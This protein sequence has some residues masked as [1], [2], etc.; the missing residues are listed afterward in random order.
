MVLVGKCRKLCSADEMD[1]VE[2]SRLTLAGPAAASTPGARL[3]RTEPHV[4]Y[5][6]SCH[7]SLAG[8]GHPYQEKV[9]KG[10]HDYHANQKELQNGVPLKILLTGQKD[11]H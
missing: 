6:Y 7:R 9:R 10:R 8:S 4:G 3:T 11:P 2:T 5:P 1:K